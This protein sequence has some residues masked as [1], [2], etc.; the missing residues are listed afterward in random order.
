MHVH[1]AV[2]HPGFDGGHLR[3]THHGVDEAGPT[4]RDHHV[5]E[6]TR[7]DEVSHGRPVPAVEQLDRVGGQAT[8]GQ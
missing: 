2:A 7:L 4:A 5:N 8:G 3:V 1:V 6:P